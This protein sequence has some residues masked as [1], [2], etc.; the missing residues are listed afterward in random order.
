LCGSLRHGCAA[1]GRGRRL[2]SDWH[3]D[4]AVQYETLIA[5]KLSAKDD[6]RKVLLQILAALEGQRHFV[7]MARKN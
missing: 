1:E 4:L 2:G 7:G 6:L 5:L 3:D